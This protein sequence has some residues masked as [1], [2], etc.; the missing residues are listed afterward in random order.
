MGRRS[1]KSVTVTP[2][3]PAVAG[4]IDIWPILAADASDLAAEVE[5]GD[6]D[7]YL[8]FMRHC[9]MRAERRRRPEVLAAI[10]ARRAMR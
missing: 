10:D 6:H 1:L 2:E 9:E 3:D 4:Q 5:R 8:D 7:A